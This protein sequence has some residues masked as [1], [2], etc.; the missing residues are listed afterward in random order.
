[1]I[2]TVGLATGKLREVRFDRLPLH[3]LRNL[4]HFTGQNLWF[5]SLTL[6]TLAQVFALE[7]TSPIWVMIFAALFLGE[8]LTRVRLLAVALGFLGALAV[9]RPGAGGD[10][11]G[12]A[13]AATSAIG[14]AGSIVC[15]KMLTRTETILGILFW[16]TAMQAVM[17]LMTTGWDGDI[18]WPSAAAWPWVALIGCAGLVA[19]TCLT[20]ALAVAPATV[21][22]PMDF[23]R[24]PVIAMVGMAVYG[25]PLDIWVFV[26]AALI[27]GGNYVNIL[28]ESQK[29]R[30]T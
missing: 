7:F 3:V 23:L 14:F 18:A 9:A 29:R 24:L 10:P 5:Y 13:L 15:T 17:G 30:R 26:G 27:F 25:E 12:L 1:V 2:L 22:T 16:L 20:N 21:V 11:L 8:G 4:A 19:H 6:I 28:T